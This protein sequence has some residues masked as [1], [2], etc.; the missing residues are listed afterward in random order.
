L[1]ENR[2]QLH[3][4]SNVIQHNIV[5][6]ILQG[7]IEDSKY[8]L[9][10]LKIVRNEISLSFK[11]TKAHEMYNISLHTFKKNSLMMASS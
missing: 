10:K 11:K 7:Y 8:T 5:S 9:L 6:T 1:Y 4:T 3:L 2:H